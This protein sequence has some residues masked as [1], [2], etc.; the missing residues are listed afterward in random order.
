M[1]IQAVL[2]MLVLANMVFADD[3]RGLPTS[4][5]PSGE[6]MNMD[7]E[8]DSKNHHNIPREQYGNWGNIDNQHSLEGDNQ[9]PHVGSG[10]NH[11]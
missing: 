7:G 6:R 3:Q 5:G 8:A 10:D 9:S 2:L 4:D 1:K 11:S